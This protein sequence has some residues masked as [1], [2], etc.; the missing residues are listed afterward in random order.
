[1]LSSNSGV[2]TDGQ[3]RNLTLKIEEKVRVHVHMS[4]NMIHELYHLHVFSFF[5][6]L[7]FPSIIAYLM[8]MTILFLKIK[9]HGVI[10]TLKQHLGKQ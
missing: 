8:I 6:K 9:K 10:H 3:W 5:R 4:G 2:L 7:L 1:M